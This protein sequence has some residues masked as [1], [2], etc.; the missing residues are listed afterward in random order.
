VV[1]LFVSAQ[2]INEAEERFSMSTGPQVEGFLPPTQPIG[3]MRRPFDSPLKRA[4]IG[5]SFIAAGLASAYGMYEGSQSDGHLAIDTPYIQEAQDAVNGV[6]GVVQ[7]VGEVGLV[8]ALGVIG[9]TKIASKWSSQARAVDFASSKEMTNDG[10]HNPGIARRA[11]QSTFAGN[12]PVIASVGVALG[13]FTGAIGT[14]VSEG[15]SRPIEAFDQFAPGDAMVVQYNGAMPMV[16]SSVNNK[17]AAAVRAEAAK[18]DV[19]V[20]P[21]SL[22][23]GEMV[24]PDKQSFSDLSVGM[25]VPTG[26]ILDWKPAEGCEM[27]PVEVDKTA[28]LN[29][30]DKVTLNGIS[31]QVVGQLEGSSA[32]NRVGIAM[33]REVMKDC[34]EQD[35]E[36]PDH[37]LV[38]DTDKATAQDILTV[39]RTGQQAPATVITKADYKENSEEFWVANVKPI[40]NIL[41]LSA[42]GAVLMSLGGNLRARLLRNRREWAADFAR[43]IS[44]NK[45]RSVELLRSAKD[46]VLA[47]GV[48]VAAATAITPVANSI[49]AGFHA[50]V[51]YKEA[52][53]GA[54]VGIIG[55]VG[56]A[57]AK[58]FR[59]RKTINPKE[60]TR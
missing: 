39:A 19:K 41:A 58:L 27:I 50:G 59:P 42:I 5:G 33:D 29:L 7:T 10:N 40:T 15:P 43:H 14:E 28:D 24:T 6:D 20:T 11:L 8:A 32:I 9:A 53:I 16:Q 45:M 36:A 21:L 22:N 18:R 48:G 52:M 34:M 55:S 47:S 38:L 56:G 26:S 3:A 54:G 31:A 25:D 49:V 57:A 2:L 23:L 1:P 12:I 30:G 13:T 60:Y 4:I 44:E 17:L 35:A 51:G 46:G 37:A